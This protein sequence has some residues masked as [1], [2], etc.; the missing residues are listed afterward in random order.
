MDKRSR[1][2]EGLLWRN[3]NID[4]TLIIS[5]KINIKR[6][7]FKQKVGINTVVRLHC[8]VFCDCVV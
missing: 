8:I 6:A 4:K 7:L 5:H 1:K 3:D 2:Y